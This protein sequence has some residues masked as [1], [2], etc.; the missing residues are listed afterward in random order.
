MAHLLFQIFYTIERPPLSQ[1][2]DFQKY[3]AVVFGDEKI[4]HH[5]KTSNN[6]PLKGT[7]IIY[8]LS[9]TDHQM[10]A[11]RENINLY[12]YIYTLR[13]QKVWKEFSIEFVTSY[14][15]QLLDIRR[16]VHWVMLIFDNLKM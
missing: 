7:Q 13:D 1:S 15:K 8:I 2:T 4:H 10:F 6:I 3:L 5:Q 9:E 12:M 14:E 11:G 16:S